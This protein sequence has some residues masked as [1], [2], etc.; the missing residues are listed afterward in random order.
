MTVS[1]TAAV[2]F[3]VDRVCQRAMQ[4]AGLLDA[5]QGTESPNWTERSAMARDFLEAE[6]EHLQ[7]LG[8]LQRAREFYDLDVVE[9]TATYTLPSTTLDVFGVAMFAAD[10]EDTQTSVEPLVQDG[11][12]RLT[13]KTSEG[14]PTLYFVQRGTTSTLYLW[15]VP[16]EDG[17]LTLQRH[18]LLTTATEGGSTTLDLERHWNEVLLWALAHKLAVAAGMSID[19]CRYMQ[20]NAKKALERAKAISTADFADTHLRLSHRTGWH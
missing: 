17:T 12:Q 16:D 3:D 4:L 7:T 14:R 13:D 9:G 15:P 11:Y 20:E 19:R 18:K 5:S 6:I 1:S 10:G 8:V 2:E